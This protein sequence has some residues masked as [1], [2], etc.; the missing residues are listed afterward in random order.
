LGR[1]FSVVAVSASSL[2][3]AVIVSSDKL[4]PPD[5]SIAGMIFVPC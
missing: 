3:T 2:I 1:F 4:A 5:D